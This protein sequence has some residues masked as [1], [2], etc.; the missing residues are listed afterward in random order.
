VTA[1]AHRWY[2]AELVLTGRSATARLHFL[3]A[4]RL[5]PNLPTAV[6]LGL[7]YLP[8]QVRGALRKVTR[9]IRARLR[10]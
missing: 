6:L 9:G 5:D 1:E 4:L 7:A 8:E 3:K 10:A 2:A